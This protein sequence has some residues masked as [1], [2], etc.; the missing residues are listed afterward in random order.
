MEMSNYSSSNRQQ[1]KGT[2]TLSHLKAKRSSFTTR[3]KMTEQCLSQVLIKAQTSTPRSFNL[4]LI[5]R[6]ELATKL[7]KDKRK[8]LTKGQHLSSRI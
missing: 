1:C 8:S 2:Y 3:N 4:K 7:F 6:E 5:I